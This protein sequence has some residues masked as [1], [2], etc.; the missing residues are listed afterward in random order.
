MTVARRARRFRTSVM[1][2][3]YR[4]PPRS[5]SGRPR[6]GRGCPATVIIPAGSTGVPSG[7]CAASSAVARISCGRADGREPRREVHGA[8]GVVVA[9]EQDHGAA[10]ASRRASTS[11]SSSSWVSASSFAHRGDE[12]RGL[13]RHEHAA[14][15]EPLRDAH[16]EV[17]RDL[18]HRAA[19]QRE[20]PHRLVVAEL[21]AERREAREV[22]EREPALDSH[23]RE[24]LT[25][26][27]GEAPVTKSTTA[28]GH[29]G[30]HAVD[31]QP[32][33]L[34]RLEAVVTGLDPVERAPGPCIF[35]ACRFSSAGRPNASRVPLTNST[36]MRQSREVLDA[37]LLRLARRVQRIAEQREAERGNG[38]SASAATIEQIRP[39]IE[40][41]PSTS[42]S[43]GS[44]A[45]RAS[46]AA[47]SRT[48]AS[49]TGGA[50]GRAPARGAV[51]EVEAQRR[52]LARRRARRRRWSAS[53]RAC[54]RPRRARAAPRDRRRASGLGTRRR[55]SAHVSTIA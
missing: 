55:S 3:R 26:P 21:V 29:V 7:A 4:R 43:G 13:D 51:R 25:S 10:G 12:L 38:S 46:S 15:A 6:P 16:A 20:H 52:D 24:S 35:F 22:D 34:Q 32:A 37:E 39:P 8:A 40:R 28:A 54:R 17:G 44:L 42:R 53:P 18:A 2:E 45:R 19:E 50:I 30:E 23:A 49:S 14:V 33:R 36:G 11:G 31:G 47:A 1:R 48:A 41:P 9:L 5:R 27:F